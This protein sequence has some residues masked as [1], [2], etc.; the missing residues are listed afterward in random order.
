L[1]RILLLKKI[2]VL[3]AVF[4]RHG[5]DHDIYRNP[6]TGKEEAIPRH[7][8]IPEG[9]ANRIMTLSAALRRRESLDRKFIIQAGYIP[10]LPIK[11]MSK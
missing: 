4:V 10:G 5:A 3:D 8:D 7:S 2:T 6:R 9:L 1:K 11:R